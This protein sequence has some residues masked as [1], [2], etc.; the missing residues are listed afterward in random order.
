MSY[1]VNNLN[2]KI[3]YKY[4]KGKKPGIVFI[5]GLN[6]NMEGEKAISIQKYAKRKGLSFLRFDCRGHGKS[7]GEFKDFV[8]SDWKKDLLDIL[9]NILKGPQILIGSSMGGWLMMLAAKS[10][11]SKIIGLIG[12][13]A[14]P[15]FTKSLYSQL[16]QISKRKIKKQGFIE[17]KEL[18]FTYIYTKKLFDDGKKNFVL[19]KKLNFSKPII[20]L[21]GLK[22]RVV[23]YDISKKILEKTSSNNIQIRYLKSGNHSLSSKND[24]KTICNA[25]DN[26]LAIY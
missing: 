17:Y 19:N 2:Q 13:A 23:S 14:A 25:I 5:H 24:I 15:D 21:H 11:P 12:I 4:Y 6:S 22:D 26:V 8:I 1:F 10:R 9:D 18:N 20:L 3:A 7:Y 16:S